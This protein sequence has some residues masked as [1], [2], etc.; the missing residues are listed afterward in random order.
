VSLEEYQGLLRRKIFA[1][2]A[3]KAPA[4]EADDGDGAGAVPKGRGRQAERPAG[5]EES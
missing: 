5:A 3:A 2:A 1:I 4:D